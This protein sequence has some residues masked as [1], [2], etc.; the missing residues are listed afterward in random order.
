MGKR[1]GE[2]CNFLEHPRFYKGQEVRKRDRDERGGKVDRQ[3][4]K[5]SHS[6]EFIIH[7]KDIKEKCKRNYNK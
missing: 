4:G 7:E 2:N 5:E 3:T 1:N 6:C